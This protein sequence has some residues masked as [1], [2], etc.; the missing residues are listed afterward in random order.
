MSVPAET[1]DLR[2]VF[3][4]GFAAT[5]AADIATSILSAITTVILIRG[6]SVSNYAYA[7]LFL[8]FAQ[9]LAS[10]A[11]SGVR[12]RYLRE[13][14][15]RVSR[16]SQH[17]GT[18]E[19]VMSLIKGTLLICALAVVALPIADAVG[20]AS[21]V[22]GSTVLIL[23]S[24]A[25]AI[26]FGAVEFAIAHDQ[27]ERRFLVAGAFRVARA[28]LLL[29]ASVAVIATDQSPDS[30]SMWF[31]VSMLAVGFVTTIAPA[32]RQLP[33]AWRALNLLRFN[34][35]EMWLSF[36]YVAASGFAYVDVMVAGALLTKH[37]VASL[38]ASLRY[39]AIALA[40]I[41]ALGA[42]LRVRTAQV[43]VVDSPANQNAMVIGWLRRAALPAAVLMTLAI[44]LAP[45]VIP[46]IDG[47]RYP[48][49][50]PTLQIF[51]VTALTAYLTAPVANVL[52]AQRHYATLATIYAVGLTLNLVG[53]I[54]VA[55]P[56]GIIGLAVV[57]TAVYVCID[58]AMS[59]AAVRYARSAA[60]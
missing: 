28:A 47:G 27:A 43:D 37:E 33:S 41:P 21:D 45:F 11:T 3:R 14:A 55:R 30:I 13:E 6:L 32:I 57:S 5:F 24:T 2:R 60:R 39:L 7:T 19:F 31:V 22:G 10:A 54:V 12:T 56:Y 15:E 26:G 58:A 17:D 48:S 16:G 50:I 49:S 52:M 9:F 4:R 38:G 59:M 40:A 8:T 53:D 1:L 20:F 29:I 35:E 23:Y 44:V 25:F 34:G 36:Y 18:T 42:V 51:L 46:L